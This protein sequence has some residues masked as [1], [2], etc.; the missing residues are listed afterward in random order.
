MAGLGKKH[1]LD[2]EY[3]QTAPFFNDL[4]FVIRVLFDLLPLIPRILVEDLKLSFSPILHNLR[5]PGKWLLS[6]GLNWPESMHLPGGRGMG[7]Y[8]LEA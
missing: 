3:L 4:C 7:V 5:N 6:C 2:L 1:G 8:L